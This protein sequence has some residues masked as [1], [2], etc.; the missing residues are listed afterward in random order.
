MHV[1]QGL[2]A[3][4]ICDGAPL[5]EYQATVDSS[6]QGQ[7]KATAWIASIVDKVRQFR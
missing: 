7:Y 5:E 2:S 1:I 4:I 6:I 3:S